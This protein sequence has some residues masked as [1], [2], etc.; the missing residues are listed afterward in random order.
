[1]A[2]ELMDRRNDLF[3]G[4]ND[5]FNDDHFFN[6]LG[7]TLYGLSESDHDLK[8]DIKETDQDYQV[9][10]ELPGLDKKDINVSY[11]QDTLKISGK[12][13]SF[14]DHADKNGNSLMSERRYGEFVRQYRLP[15]I[16]ADQI[17]GKYDK[18]VLQVTLPKAEPQQ[19]SDHNIQIQ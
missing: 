9:S 19:K 14:D 6:N 5:W 12:R 8:T 4:L 15:N 2:N 16:K 3:G 13:D 7:R 1:M 10:V 11:D 17:T 18:G